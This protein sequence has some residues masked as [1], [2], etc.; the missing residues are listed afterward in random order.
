MVY[1]SFGPYIGGH[2]AQAG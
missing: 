1:W 2:V